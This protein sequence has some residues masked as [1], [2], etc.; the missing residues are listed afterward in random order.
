MRRRVREAPIV[1]RQRA[2]AARS[3]AEAGD[4]DLACPREPARRR[5]V[6]VPPPAS[7]QP[8]RLVGVGS[9]GVA[10]RGRRRQADPP[11]GGLLRVPLVP[12]D[13]ARV[14][15]GRR[16]RRSDERW[17]RLH[18]GRPR[19]TS[20]HRRD[21]H[22]SGAS[23]LGPRRLADDG[24]HDFRRPA[25]LRRH[26]L[27]EGPVPPPALGHHRHMARE[28]RRAARPGGPDHAVAQPHGDDDDAR[29]PDPPRHRRAQQRAAADRVC[30]RSRVG[31]FRQATE[32]PASDDARALPP[33][34]RAQRG[35]WSSH[36]RQHVARRDGVGWHVRPSRRRLRPLL[37]RR[38]LDG[39]P[40]REDAVRPGA[41]GPHL[42]AR[43]AAARRGSLEA[44]ARRD[45]HVRVAR[46]APAR[47]RLLVGRGR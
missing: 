12:R 1:E 18:Q 40:L 41:A 45:S 9:R 17:L 4:E 32:V 14:V 8:S 24:L 31:R 23:D 39:P 7:R 37:G 34:P 44:G 10:S 5:D 20:R 36:G 16:S 47:G 25:F 29:G 35:R 22:G 27:P 13:G 46:P 28:A 33:R 43:L 15:R 21:L 26:V 3:G 42:P 38:V 19:R 6:A 2:G 11:L 30:V